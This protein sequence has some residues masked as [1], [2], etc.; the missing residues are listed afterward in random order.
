MRAVEY[1]ENYNNFKI[2]LMFLKEEHLMLGSPRTNAETRIWGQV[3]YCEGE[4]SQ[5]RKTVN[6]KM[7]QLWGYHL[8]LPPPRVKDTG[9]PTKR[10]LSSLLW[11]EG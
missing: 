4:V 2:L 11:K 10:P 9:V 6:K 3:G 1:E 5:P 8:R 7:V